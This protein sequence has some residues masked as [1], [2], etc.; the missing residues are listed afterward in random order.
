MNNLAKQI[1]K[2]DFIKQNRSEWQSTGRSFQAHRESLSLKKTVVAKIIGIC[3][4][5]LTKFETGAPMNNYKLI[6]NCY[7]LLIEKW[8]NKYLMSV[9]LMQPLD[10]ETVHDFLPSILPSAL[11]LAQA[12]NKQ[13]QLNEIDDWDSNIGRRYSMREQREDLEL[14]RQT[15][16]LL[17]KEELSTIIQ[18]ERGYKVKDDDI[19]ESKYALILRYYQQNLVLRK[20]I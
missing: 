12:A 10:E 2:Q 15:I 1:M 11:K 5:T 18:F 8:E 17:A 20:V 7:T 9:I 14:S 6:L 13:N 16:A 4:S 3:T 19:V